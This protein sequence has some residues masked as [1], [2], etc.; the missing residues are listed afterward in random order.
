MQ[1]YTRVIPRDLFNE[2]GLLKSLG[3]LAIALGETDGHDAR[4]AQ[5]QLDG[6]DISQ[7]PSDGSIEV[8]NLDLVIRGERWALRRSLN[9][10]AS[11]GLWAV[12]GDEEVD[13]LEEDGSLTADFLDLIGVREEA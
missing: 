1:D 3:R 12:L 7:D 5:E 9:S 8:A 10:R 4:F 13:V 6:F 11:Y 2:A